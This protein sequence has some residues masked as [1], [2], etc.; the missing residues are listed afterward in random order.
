MQTRRQQDDERFE[1]ILTRIARA[2]EN[3]VTLGGVD[4]KTAV[5]NKR[6]S[7]AA[8][9]VEWAALDARRRAAVRRDYELSE[10]IGAEMLRE[11]LL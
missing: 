1:E 7:K 2:A 3:D 4:I 5:E 6:L 10:R 8:P 9:A 11:V